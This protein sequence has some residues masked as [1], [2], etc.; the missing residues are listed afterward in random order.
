V[1][2]EEIP[3]TTP[4]RPVRIAIQVQPQHGEY[5]QLR[6]MVLTSEELGVDIVYNWDHFFPLSGDPDGKHFECWTMLGSMAEMTSSVEIGALVSCNSY[7]NPE[8]LG[9]MAR[10]VDHI[11]GGRLILGVGAG[12]QVRDYDAFGYE[13]GTAPDRLRALDADL[14]RTI[15]RMAVGNPPPTRRIPILV[16]GGGEKVTLRIAAQHADIWHG[17][18]D[19]ETL[20]RKNRILDDHCRRLG[21]DPGEIERSCGTRPS[22]LAGASALVAAGISQIT[23]G[24]DATGFDAVAIRSWVAWRDEHNAAPRA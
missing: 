3:L 9:D 22:N 23:L 14:P 1:N 4:A 2:P 12:W 18:G 6:D 8:L 15:A 13:F 10:T 16:G 19:A 11:S 21:R 17:F 5:A 20:E 24:V 7:R